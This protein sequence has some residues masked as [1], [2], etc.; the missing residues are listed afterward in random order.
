MRGLGR[1]W[2]PARC[3]GPPRR[4][5]GPGSPGA[6]P[7]GRRKPAGRPPRPPR[8]GPRASLPHPRRCRWFPLPWNGYLRPALAG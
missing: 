7:P 6:R 4:P 3:P 5:R 8:I 1:A 2:W